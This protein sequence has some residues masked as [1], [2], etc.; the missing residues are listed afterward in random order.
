MTER[1]GE[2]LERVVATGFGTSV[3][4]WMLGYIAR[5]PPA[6][7]PSWSV[8][9]G[10]L[11]CLLG[12]GVVLGRRGGTWREG[13]VA[14][15]LASTLNL[16]ILG[17]LLGGDAPNRIRTG[18]AWWL[19]ASLALGA[20]LVALGAGVSSRR[21]T[22][23]RAGWSG[24]MAKIAAAATF[25]LV[26]A[27]GLVTSHGAGLA[28]VDWPNSFGYTMFLY[29]LSR[30]T[31]GIYYEHAHRLF[32]SLVGL[33]TVALAVLLWRREPRQ[34][35]R[36]LALAAVPL[37]AVQ[38]V[39]GGLRVTGR[40]TLATSPD[41]VAP[42]LAI[43]VVHGTLA[44]LFL[45]LVVVIAA[46]TSAAWQAAPAPRPDPRAGA[47]RGLTVLLLPVL[48]VQLVLGALQ[49]H[50][51]QLL[52]VHI[53]FAVVVSLVALAAAVRALGLYRDLPVLPALGRWLIW[54]VGAQLTLGVGAF[55]AITTAAPGA[56][57]SA[58]AVLV[59]TAHQANGALL[60]AVAVLLMAWARR[61]LGRAA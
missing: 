45:S 14:G 32:G 11:A 15:L 7:L 5:L 43:A 33:T 19:P 28:V 46:A 50:T 10:M 24:A 18:V 41:A 9:V 54:L 37:V 4:M 8:G 53:C 61:L 39:L 55:L 12:G 27:G 1:D 23:A 38:G 59:R 3:A 13:A 20:A 34:W 40:F 17:S 2:A 25:L 16:L 57:P 52:L 47:D 44:Q 6:A 31:G 58:L 56:P 29:P 21:A 22:G 35:V 30:M 26:V 36:S 49:R 60:L 42:N 48:I 51:G